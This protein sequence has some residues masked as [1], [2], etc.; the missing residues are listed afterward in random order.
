MKRDYSERQPAPHGRAIL[1]S[2]PAAVQS[3]LSEA[4]RRWRN[5]AK[6]E[7]KTLESAWLGLG[8]PREY[9]PAV[10]AGLM[11]PLSA[12]RPRCLQWYLLT[13]AGVRALRRIYGS[14]I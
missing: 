1:A 10:E 6:P 7:G 5:F 13:P 9:R 3:A 11:R 2:Y 4:E 12:E 14:R 8:Y